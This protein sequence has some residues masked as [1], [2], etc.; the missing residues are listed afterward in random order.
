MQWNRG[1]PIRAHQGSHKT[2]LPTAF[3]ANEPTE[4]RLGCAARDVTGWG[5]SQCIDTRTELASRLAGRLWSLSWELV[6]VLASLSLPR[7]LTAP[8]PRV[9]VRNTELAHQWENPCRSSI[10]SLDPMR[11]EG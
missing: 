8:R 4:E 5:L 1:H 10:V 6:L 3:S 7:L 9:K 2:G 11:V